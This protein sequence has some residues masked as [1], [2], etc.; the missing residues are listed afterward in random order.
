MT[1]TLTLQCGVT[2]HLQPVK[3][4]V[5]QN[6]LAEFGDVGSL[7]NNPALL[8]H[9]TGGQQMKA[10][11]ATEKLFT[12]CA[13]WGVAN[14]PPAESDE[15]LLSVL[16]GGGDGPHV[17]RA[18]WVRYVL[19]NGQGEMGELIGAVMALSFQEEPAVDEKERRIRELEAQLNA[20]KNGAVADTAVSFNASQD[21]PE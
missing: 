20:M 21:M 13:G 6:I 16:S 14:E 3:R 4:M 19:V 2:L 8:R 10:L 17:R 15:E 12:Y 11:A 1:N 9:L 5:L 18:N 7:M